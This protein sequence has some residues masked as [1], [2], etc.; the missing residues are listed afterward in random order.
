MY[1]CVR[2]FEGDTMLAFRCSVDKLT[3]FDLCMVHALESCRLDLHNALLLGLSQ[4]PV[5]KIQRFQNTEAHI[6]TCQK[7]TW[8]ITLILRELHWLPVRYRIQYKVPLQ[9]YRALNTLSDYLTS[10]LALYAPSRPWGLHTALRWLSHA[11]SAAGV[12]VHSARLVWCCGMVCRF[13]CE[14]HLLLRA[15]EGSWKL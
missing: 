4:R 2:C 5:V 6:F 15:S 1:R 9:V 13:L 3:L 11:L 8:H 10:T 7:K 14:V 12:T